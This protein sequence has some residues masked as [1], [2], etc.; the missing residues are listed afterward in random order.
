MT[1]SLFH[2]LF[3]WYRGFIQGK[4]RIVLAWLFAAILVF[5]AR[6]YPNIPGILICCVGAT[7][8]FW[9]SGYLRKDRFPAVGGPYGYTR[10]PLYV[11][12]YLMAIGAAFAI[13]N[14]PFFVFV[15]FAYAAVYHYIILDEE[16]KL[17]EIFG[18]NYELYKR[19]VSRFFPKPWPTSSE[20]LL[21]INPKREHHKFSWSLAM[22][23]KAYEAYAACAGLVGFLYAIAFFWKHI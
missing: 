18:E 5:S 12:T 7:L 19:S 20:K 17:S 8:R 13:W 6:E 9:A 22:D 23:N 10:N 3:Q 11:G 14:I 16:N 21:K 15:S 1:T 2:N 4:T